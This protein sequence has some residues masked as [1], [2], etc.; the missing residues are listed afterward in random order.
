MCDAWEP[1]LSSKLLHSGIVLIINF[2][3]LHYPLQL[4]DHFEIKQSAPYLL[5]LTSEFQSVNFDS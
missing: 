1:Y 4:H 3:E 2:K 5:H